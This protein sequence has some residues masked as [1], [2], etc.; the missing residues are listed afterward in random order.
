VTELYVAPDA[1]R[2]G[3]AT[4]LLARLDRYFADAGCDAVRI[5]VFAPN[6]AARSLYE[7]LAYRVR[8]LDLIRPIRRA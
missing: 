2:R 5:E 1:R 4:R 7:R 6:L 3:I 8:D